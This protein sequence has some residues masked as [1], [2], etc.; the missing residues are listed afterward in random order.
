MDPRMAINA[1]LNCQLGED[2]P[3]AD[4]IIRWRRLFSYTYS[5]V[6]EKIEKH[7]LVLIY[8]RVFEDLWALL[9]P[10]FKGYDREAYKHKL[11]LMAPPLSFSR[12]HP[13]QKSP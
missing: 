5:E 4:D 8:E 3:G 12:V 6:K 2:G 7:K 10:Q 9:L 1:T 11:T 13:Y